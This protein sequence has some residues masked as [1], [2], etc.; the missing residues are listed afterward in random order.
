MYVFISVNVAYN[1]L[2]V[3]MS[4]VHFGDASRAVDGNTESEYILFSCTH[5]DTENNPWWYVDLG[6]EENIHRVELTNRLDSWG[7]H[8][9]V[10]L[11]FFFKFLFLFL[12]THRLKI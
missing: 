12:L 10:L 6:K 7:K 5:T 4:T 1:K 9:V 3:Q 2:A 8:E 11:I